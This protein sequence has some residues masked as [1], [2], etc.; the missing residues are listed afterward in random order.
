[1]LVI[2]ALLLVAAV[3]M[4]SLSRRAG[5]GSITGYLAA[6]AIIGPSGL[7][8]VTD[9]H[10]IEEISELGVLML[11]FLIGLELR[12]P[13]IW[14]MRKSVFGLGA[15]QVLAAGAALA[16]LA[17]LA[18]VEWRAAAILGAGLAL[19]STAIV[20]PMLGERN[21]LQL[22][23]GRDAFAVLLFQDLASV[24]LVALVPVLAGAQA[25]GPVWPSVVKAAV[26]VA[27]IL[28][29]GR[30]LVGPLFRAVGGVKTREVF[31][32]TALLVV[33]GAAALAGA[34]GLPM[35][36]PGWCS[37][38]A[39]TGT[40]CRRTS[41]HSRACCSASSSCRWAC[42]P[43]WPWPGGSQRTSCWGSPGCWG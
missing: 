43:T 6:G 8:L 3:V 31:T 40:S 36:P 29:G 30:Y 16:G 32:A 35:S 41:S 21:L 4:V 24:P 27:A 22:S 39:N 42:R 9:V 25:S 10:S 15:G 26:A 7:H 20:L 38:R 23:S 14:A 17:H 5:F 13:R 33:A 18:G 19:S 28:L 2:L 11:L 1:M 37:P 34:A 12:L